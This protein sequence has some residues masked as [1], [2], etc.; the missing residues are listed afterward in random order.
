MT[1]APIVLALASALSYGTGDF[2]GGEGGRRSSPAQ[3]SVL[4]QL[5]GLMAASCAVLFSARHSPSVAMISWGALS[6]VGSAIGNVCLYRGLAT[7]AMNVVAP[8]SA[9]VTVMVPAVVGIAVG[10]HFDAAGWIG[11]AIALPAIALVSLTPSR[12]GERDAGA[13]AGAATSAPA[14]PARQRSALSVGFGWGLL[15]GCGFGL[16]FVAL[17]QAG[18]AAGA[19]PLLPG[20]TV[21]LTLVLVLTHRSHRSHSADEPGSWRSALP[22]GIASGVGGA[23][24]NILFFTATANGQ[25]TIVAVLTSLYPAVTVLLAAAALHERASRTQL[26]GLAGAATA[27]VLISSA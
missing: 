21:A 9:V 12:S 13:R 5:T 10:D 3:M 6:G 27:V 8:V 19:W 1:A 2:L 15:A 17:D 11:L 24:G 18:T 14:D 26:L 25:L 16:L 7:G 20:Q 4:I 22:W 23:G